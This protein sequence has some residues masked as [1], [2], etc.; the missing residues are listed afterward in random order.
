MPIAATRATRLNNDVAVGLKD[1]R[2]ITNSDILNSNLNNSALVDIAMALKIADFAKNTLL[3]DMAK[4]MGLAN[5]L[6]SLKAIIGPQIIK[7]L[8]GLSMVSTLIAKALQ[9]ASI[10]H[11]VAGLNAVLMQLM[12]AIANGSATAI[13]NHLTSSEQYNSIITGKIS[14]SNIALKSS[15]SS[16]SVST[17]SKVV[18]ETN[19]N[20]KANNTKTNISS[21]STNSNT[22]AL[23][24]TTNTNPKSNGIP[25]FTSCLYG[26]PNISETLADITK[27]VT[28]TGVLSTGVIPVN[29]RITNVP[30][31]SSATSSGTQLTGNQ[32]TSMLNKAI[33]NNPALLAA[34]KTLPTPILNNILLSTNSAIGVTSKGDNGLTRTISDSSNVGSFVS[35]VSKITSSTYAPT[36]DNSTLIAKLTVALVYNAINLGLPPLYSTLANGSIINDKV[37]L[38]KAG[39]E[40]LG[41]AAATGDVAGFIDVTNTSHITD[42]ALG[43]PN[44]ISDLMT[45]FKLPIGYSKNL[46]AS[47]TKTTTTNSVSVNG[48]TPVVSTS[49]VNKLTTNTPSPVSQASQNILIDNISTSTTSDNGLTTQNVIVKGN[50]TTTVITTP[51]GTTIQQVTVNGNTTT[52]V[53]NSPSGNTT[54]SATTNGNTVT[55]IINSS[56]GT[57]TIQ[58]T[59]VGNTVTTNTTF[60][61]VTPSPKSQMI[62]LWNS[63]QNALNNVNPNWLLG[64]GRDSISIAKFITM[65]N[66]ILELLQVASFSHDVIIPDY[67]KSTDE[68][69]VAPS[70]IVDND[71]WVYVAS[72]YEIE[73]VDVALV[74]AFPNM[75]LFP[76]T[77]LPSLTI[78][79]SMSNNIGFVDT[80]NGIKLSS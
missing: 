52:T 76:D 53:V 55:T 61:E 66:D 4:L 65:S 67:S 43:N 75:R 19:V 40:V 64:V 14:T 32:V 79:S 31:M 62:V 80:T 23:S 50:T 56:S 74:N 49:V 39:I 44:A 59:T 10:F 78:N 15:T 5:N 6:N 30:H 1:F 25:D 9:T 47:I 18:I 70:T 3:P 20:N 51:T 16:K 69:F 48:D 27:A 57:K 36:I 45:N 34:I 58:E 46:P 29:S 41:N 12:K 54:T 72:T 24:L 60:V 8:L 73:E 7:Q 38:T 42:I 63:L 2:K 22:K 71:I 13:P 21:N 17:S 11:G 68:L 28:L 37:A 35:S 33:P 77:Q 26:V